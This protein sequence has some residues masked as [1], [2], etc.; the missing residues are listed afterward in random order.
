[1]TSVARLRRYK[2]IYTGIF[3]FCQYIRGG[4]CW[5]RRYFFQRLLAA[6]FLTLRRVVGLT[7]VS[8]SLSSN[9]N[10]EFWIFFLNLRR[11]FST[12]PSG[13]TST[14]RPLKANAA[15]Y[16]RACGLFISSA[17]ISTYFVLVSR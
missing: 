14:D 11:A 17:E 15:S 12:L 5:L 6:P 2:Y 16:V 10:P 3:G 4:I 9:S 13:P 8:R 7:K 1:M